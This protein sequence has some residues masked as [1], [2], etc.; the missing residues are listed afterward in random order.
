MVVVWIALIS[1]TCCLKFVF[2]CSVLKCFVGGFNIS[3]FG[4]GVV[5]LSL[6]DFLVLLLVFGFWYLC[7]RVTSCVDCIG[8]IV[9]EFLFYVVLL[10]WCLFWICWLF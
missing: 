8:V 1:V 10:L 3:E 6:C 4:F 2:V 5:R 9:G 7:A